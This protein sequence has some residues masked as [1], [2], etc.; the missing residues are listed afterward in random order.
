MKL[1]T[2]FLIILLGGLLFPL[3]SLAGTYWASY[4]TNEY[5]VTYEG[6][7]P[8]GKMVSVNGVDQDVSCQFCHFFVMIDGIIDFIL[9][10]IVP[11]VATLLLII[12]GIMFLFSG[13]DPGKLER[14]KK[15]LT[16]TVIG[17]VIILGSFLVVGS[18]FKAVGVADIAGLQDWYD[19]G[20]FKIECPI[21]LPIIP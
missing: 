11:P 8:C 21:S 20:F 14:G 2:L 9:L 1:K 15:I 16:S 19:N 3:V 18:I 6:L 17:L 5:V 13:G 7:V 4:G 12:G 10:K